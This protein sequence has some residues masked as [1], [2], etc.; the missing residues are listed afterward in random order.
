[1][2]MRTTCRH[3]SPRPRATLRW[4]LRCAAAK[5]CPALT[6]AI[7]VSEVVRLAV[8]F[9]ARLTQTTLSASISRSRGLHAA[10]VYDEQTDD[11]KISHD[12]TAT[13]RRMVRPLHHSARRIRSSPNIQRAI[14]VCGD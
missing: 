3:T 13:E 1:M 5:K 10:R 2:L 9:P 6:F 12:H 14:E 8:S 4:K 7:A 11:R